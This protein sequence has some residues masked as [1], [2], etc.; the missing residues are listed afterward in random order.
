MIVFAFFGAGLV[1]LATCARTVFAMS[2]DGRFPAHR[3]LR[4]VSP[5]THTPIPATIFIA[6]VGVVLMVVL[7]GDAL[8]ELLTVGALIGAAL[9]GAILVLYLAVRNRLDRQ[10]DAFDLGRFEVPVTV[11][12]L[13]WSGFVAFMLVS[14]HE[15]R[16]A[17]LISIGI[18]LVGGI[19]WAYLLIANRQVLQTEPG[20]ADVFKH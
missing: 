11:G 5:R 2:R 7:P 3:L 6:L 10:E 18:V 20:K 8:T 15:A 12:A 13:V 14:P 1:T 19:Y 17:I 16:S 9:Y 4:R